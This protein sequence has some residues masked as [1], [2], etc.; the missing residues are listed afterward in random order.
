MFTITPVHTNSGCT[1]H[2]RE[3]NMATPIKLVCLELFPACLHPL[4]TAVSLSQF[5]RTFSG[6]SEPP[7]AL[8]LSPR[9]AQPRQ[10]HGLVVCAH[11]VPE[12]ELCGGSPG[13]W[14]NQKVLGLYVSRTFLSHY[15]LEEGWSGTA[16]PLSPLPLS[17]VVIGA[18]TK[19]SFRWA[20]SEQ[21]SSLLLL[22]ASCHKQTLLARQGDV[23]V[24]PYHPLMSDESTQTQ[25]YLSELV[26]LECTP[27]TQGVMTIH[28]K[29]IVS[30]CRDLS[31][32][33]ATLDPPVTPSR[34]APS[35]LF[36]SDFAHYAN[37]L[38]PGSSLL[39]NTVLLSSGFAGF[40][41][42]LECRLDVKVVDV[43]SLYRQHR[44]R[45]LVEQD[46]EVDTDSVIFV[47]R[48]LLLKLGLF[49]G[50]WVVTALVPSSGKG[51]RS[52]GTGL[53]L[54]HGDADSESTSK[55]P[56]K[57]REDVHLAKVMAFDGD[58]FL[59][60]DVGDSVGFVSLVQWFNLS[61]GEPLPV[62]N[63]AVKIK[64]SRDHS[65]E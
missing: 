18:R 32:S 9:E 59:D 24:L 36:V 65:D 23:L 35:A 61:G 63:K 11:A 31:H 1:A 19:L 30:D 4:H 55:V 26:V 38:G 5:S 57:T 46:A 25:Q 37:S 39:N 56:G 54:S 48:T 20:S 27:V 43:S 34:P 53:A 22:L 52:S 12:E 40:L 28:T 62:G 7:C 15:A 2:A 42:A 3:F 17:R 60:A 64:V 16:R 49:N 14:R 58:G 6:C 51:K 47:S 13:V 29:V 33:Y 45:L 50:E 44:L 8:L 41:Q 10:K 21:F